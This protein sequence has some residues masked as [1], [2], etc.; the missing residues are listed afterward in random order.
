M[1]AF[2]H[3][4]YVNYSIIWIIMKKKNILTH[5]VASKILRRHEV[6]T[7]L[8][9]GKITHWENIYL[10]LLYSRLS[11][12]LSLSLCHWPG[13]GRGLTKWPPLDTWYGLL[14]CTVATALSTT[15]HPKGWRLSKWPPLD[16]WYGLLFVLL[17]LRW[18]RLA[19]K[20]KGVNKMA[21][22]RHVVQPSVCTVAT[23]LTT[24]PSQCSFFLLTDWKRNKRTIPNSACG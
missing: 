18:P 21:A 13:K 19:N 4:S 3:F 14:F 15:G 2:K 11:T 10:S 20:K 1:H 9:T 7:S 16:T 22:T 23:T 12:K 6:F 17:P 5:V 8:V 24:N